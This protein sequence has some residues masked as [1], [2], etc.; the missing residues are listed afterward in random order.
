MSMAEELPLTDSVRNKLIQIRKFIPEQNILRMVWK[1]L[2]W[3]GYERK[4]NIFWVGAT[5]TLFTAIPQWC[6]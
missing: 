1:G 3:I 4:F 5:T 2:N 6:P